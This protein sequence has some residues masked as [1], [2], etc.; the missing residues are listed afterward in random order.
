MGPSLIPTSRSFPDRPDNLFIADPHGVCLGHEAG[1]RV[2]AA[3]AGSESASAPSIVSG[4]KWAA[5]IDP[6]GATAG[7]RAVPMRL[8]IRS[9]AGAWRENNKDAD[10]I[11]FNDARNVA[12]LSLYLIGYKRG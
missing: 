8:R 6:S 12:V 7:P 5:P 10:M 3:G 2:P 4:S 11:G 9:W 1:T